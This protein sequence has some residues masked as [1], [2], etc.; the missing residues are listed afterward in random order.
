M[1]GACAARSKLTTAPGGTRKA[2]APRWPAWRGCWGSISGRRLGDERTAQSADTPLE[3]TREPRNDSS[4]C[5]GRLRA[6]LVALAAGWARLRLRVDRLSIR[7]RPRRRKSTPPAPPPQP[8]LP[9]P[10]DT[11]KFIV[12]PDDDVVGAVQVTVASK[13]DTLPDIARRFNVGYEEIVRANPG[14]DPGCPVRAAASWCRR[15]SCCL[16]RRARASSS[17]SRRCG[18][19]TFRRT[20]RASRRRLYLSDRH[21]QG[22][23]VDPEG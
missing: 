5:I 10:I 9:A 22:R 23:L 12:S 21:R 16:T 15:A 20:R 13:E 8:R 6:S 17:T 1:G 4:R 11:H 2:R 19:I 18:C 14:V 7:S 3:S